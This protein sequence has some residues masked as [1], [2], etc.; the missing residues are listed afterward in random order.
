LLHASSHNLLFSVD[1]A[2]YGSI[3]PE[4]IQTKH[5]LTAINTLT[6][7]DAIPVFLGCCPETKTVIMPS[8]DR[9]FLIAHDIF[10]KYFHIEAA[11]M[12]VIPSDTLGLH[13]RGTDRMASGLG[14]RMTPSEF[15]IVL[16]DFLSRNAFSTFY[17]ASD[18]DEFVQLIFHEFAEKQLITFDQFRASNHSKSGIHLSK[19][20]R[21]TR[22]SMAEAALTDLWSLSRCAV[23]FKTSSS[24][25][26]FAK[27]LNPSVSLLTV[28]GN[29][30]RPFFPEGVESNEYSEPGMSNHS[31]EIL[32]RTLGKQ[33]NYGN[34]SS[35]QLL[36]ALCRP[37]S[38]NFL[39]RG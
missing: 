35:R 31:K 24:F 33:H 28:T 30:V 9:S 18:V 2:G 13:Y 15:V 11:N 4:L 1:A 12:P 7:V 34:R 14:R 3:I 5:K 16:N 32:R 17:V 37:S 22:E 21:A 19:V 38:C 23:I 36:S 10:L 27:V 39:P 29:A 6:R 25:S 20:S 26:A 8:T